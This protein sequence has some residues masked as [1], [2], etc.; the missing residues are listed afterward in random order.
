MKEEG[1]LSEGVEER[2]D[3]EEEKRK[4]V[5]RGEDEKRVKGV[6]DQ[7]KM[8]NSSSVALRNRTMEERV[9][10]VGTVPAENMRQRAFCVEDVKLASA[11]TDCHLL[12]DPVFLVEVFRS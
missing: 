10:K 6:G 2:E 3:G 8:E 12:M 1:G 4:K 11:I 7:D 9:M 5:Q